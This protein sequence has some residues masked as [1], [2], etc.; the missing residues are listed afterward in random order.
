VGAEQRTGCDR[1][2]GELVAGGALSF[3]DATGDP[4]I[5]I[6]AQVREHRRRCAGLREKRGKGGDDSASKT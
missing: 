4:S 5:L 2:A 6:G 1:H 3:S